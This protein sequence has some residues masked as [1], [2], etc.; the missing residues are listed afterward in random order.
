MKSKL[1]SRALAIIERHKIGL[2]L[3]SLLLVVSFAL[4][5][6]SKP[7][8]W[9]RRDEGWFFYKDPPKEEEKREVEKEEKK[10][11]VEVEI[12][13]VVEPFRPEKPEPPFTEMMKKRGEELLSRAMEN[14]TINNVRAYMEHNNLMMK[15][16]ENF[17]IAWQKTLMMHP[18]LGGPAPVSDSDKD[19]YFGMVKKKEKEILM[20]LSREAGL[21]FFYSASCPSCE[22]QAA[23]L[24]R[25]M[26]E[27]P[28]FVVKSVTLDGGVLPE[29]PETMM[30]N[31]IASRLG[32]ERVP[33][34]F[35][36]F[37]PDRFGRISD[38]LLTMDELKRR[39][40][41]YAAEIDTNNHSGLSRP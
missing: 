19:L 9:E 4:P 21:F 40:I 35:L 12:P 3:I 30:D 39:L 36:A 5:A 24:R 29:F 28:Y 38:E 6:Y 15:L 14:P 10:P 17:S 25:F 34:I 22:R 18:E 2:S 27:Y 1:E 13:P 16:S 8:W 11:K 33:S 37:P 26:A 20:G 23:H 7:N 32:V 41:W 31:G